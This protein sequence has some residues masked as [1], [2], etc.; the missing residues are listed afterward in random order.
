MLKNSFSVWKNRGTELGPEP[1]LE[2]KPKNL[3]RTRTD[4][5][6][7]K[8]R[9]RPEYGRFGS[10]SVLNKKNSIPEPIMSSRFRFRFLDLKV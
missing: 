9:N 2:P 7:E 1:N 4:L 3:H 5:G 10:I 8:S 6:T